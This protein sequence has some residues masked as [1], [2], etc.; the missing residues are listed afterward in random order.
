MK[1]FEMTD[2]RGGNIFHLAAYMNAPQ[3]FNYLGLETVYLV[4]QR[5]RNGDLPLHIASKMGYVELIEKLLPIIGEASFRIGR[6][7]KGFNRVRQLGWVVK[8]AT[9]Y[10]HIHARCR[11]SLFA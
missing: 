6:R 5:D 9:S 8:K 1:L 4:Q 2:S 11:M 7:K 3:V 10:H